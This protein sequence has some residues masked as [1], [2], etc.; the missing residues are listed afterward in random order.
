LSNLSSS[1]I[2]EN[3]TVIINYFPENDKCLGGRKWNS[4]IIRKI[5]T[6]LKN[7]SNK[8]NISQYF[9]FKDATV[10]KNFDKNFTWFL[11]KNQIIENAFF[12]FHYPCFSYIIIKPNGNFYTERGEYDINT[13][14]EKIK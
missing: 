6:Y 11:D 7:L 12:P 4:F 13:I 10:V 9:I 8:E 3:N 14:I 5:K 2:N 1:K